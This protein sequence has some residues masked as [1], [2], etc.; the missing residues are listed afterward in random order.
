M[1][2]DFYA[3]V[4]DQISDGV[5]SVDRDRLITYGNGGAQRL[6]GYGAD[7]VLAA[8]APK[9]FCVTSRHAAPRHGLRPTAV[10]ERVSLGCRAERRQ[11]ARGSGLPAPQERPP[12]PGDRAGPGHPRQRRRDRRFGGGLLHPHVQARVTVSV[13][14]TMA[15]PDEAAD[16]V[17]DRA[18][19]RLCASKSAGRN[20]VTTDG[21]L[22][23]SAA[24]PPLLGT[25]VP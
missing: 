11:A 4:L 25:G 21:V 3:D 24:E 13:G 7:E 10:R 22:L 16:E 14:A 1:D 8:A 20:R 17:V 5:Y 9:G 23:V 2:E 12:R 15:V 18:D 6:T 19:R